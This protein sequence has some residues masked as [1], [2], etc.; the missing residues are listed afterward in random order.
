G[1]MRAP[2]VDQL[3]F[4]DALLKM[5]EGD[6]GDHVVRQASRAG[7]P[8]FEARIRPRDAGAYAGKRFLA[9]AGIGHPEKFFDTL[10]KAGGA[11][12][13]TRSFADH[14]FYTEEDLTE[15]ATTAAAAE[16]RLA[17]TAKDAVRLRHGMATPEFL[18]KLDVLEIDAVFELDRA[19]QRIID[20]TLSAWR[21]R[22]DE[23]GG[24]PDRTVR[25]SA[26]TT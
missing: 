18:G 12:A 14:H 6:L 17:T 21:R 5:G 20:E 23:N 22:R 11:V 10:A 1:P 2:L 16:L 19:R 7:K 15:L 9:F 26:P 4:A 25:R 24:E 13:L 3:R 8:V